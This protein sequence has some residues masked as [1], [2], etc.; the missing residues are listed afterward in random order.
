MHS[1]GNWMHDIP[2]YVGGF[3]LWFSVSGRA[4]MEWA[5]RAVRRR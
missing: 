3:A 2:L 1:C 5:R 4:A